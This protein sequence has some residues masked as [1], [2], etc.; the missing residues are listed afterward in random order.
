LQYTSPSN[1]G[2][3]ENADNGDTR[4]DGPVAKTSVPLWE[5][6]NPEEGTSNIETQQF[7]AQGSVSAAGVIVDTSN[8]L[9]LQIFDVNQQK[10]TN[11]INFDWGYAIVSG[12]FRSSSI[13]PNRAI[14]AFDA[15]QICCTIPNTDQTV[16]FNLGLFFS[17]LA[18][19]RNGNRDNGWLE[20]TYVDDTLRLGRGNKGTMF[21]L[22]R[23]PITL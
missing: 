8:K 6:V 22:T 19:F 4:E 5:P 21:I 3:Y 12:T 1:V 13:V 2:S 20:T 15:A 16:T 17:A 10:V 18:F 14:V 9:V 23:E 7:R 11:Q